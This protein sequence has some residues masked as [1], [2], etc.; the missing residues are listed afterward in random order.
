MIEIIT[1]PVYVV[2]IYVIPVTIFIYFVEVITKKINRYIWSA[3]KKKRISCQELGRVKNISGGMRTEISEREKKFQ[4]LNTYLIFEC[5]IKCLSPSENRRFSLIKHCRSAAL[6]YH[7]NHSSNWSCL[8]LF[9][10]EKNS[11]L[12]I[13]RNST[14]IPCY[15]R[16][17]CIKSSKSTH[18]KFIFQCFRYNPT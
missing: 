16:I 6:K 7:S 15:K 11:V 17:F 9:W 8:K 13:G 3:K 14:C 5:V 18:S 12:T 1:N 10:F 2:N 4:A